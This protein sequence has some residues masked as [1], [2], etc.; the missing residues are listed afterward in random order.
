MDKLNKRSGLPCGG[1]VGD[2]WGQQPA[3][4]QQRPGCHNC[5]SAEATEG[6]SSS[7]EVDSRDVLRLILQYLRENNL[8]RLFPSFLS[9]CSSIQFTFH[10]VSF[11]FTLCPSFSRAL[12]TL[13]AESNVALNTV[14]NLESF[15]ADI[16]NGRWEIVLSQ[17]N[18]HSFSIE[19]Q[20]H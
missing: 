10:L 7:I 20:C 8:T 12:H 6:M 13:Q 9:C 17:V 1:R 11:L 15:L 4:H 16:H 18:P 2:G 3:G 5:A 14:E 19:T